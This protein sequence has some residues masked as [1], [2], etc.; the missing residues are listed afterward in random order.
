MGMF[1]LFLIGAVMGAVCW[2]SAAA[3][4]GVSTDKVI[5]NSILGAVYTIQLTMLA[6]KD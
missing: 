1:L 3:N 5:Y 6:L 4:I 2:S